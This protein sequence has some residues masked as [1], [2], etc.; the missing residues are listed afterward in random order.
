[1]EKCLDHKQFHYVEGD[2]GT[3]YFSISGK[4]NESINQ[5]F[6]HIITDEKFYNEN[7]YKWLPSD[8]YSSD[9]F[10]PKFTTYIEKMG[11]DK[12]LLGYEIEKQSQ[13]MIVLAPKMYTAFNGDSIVNLKLKG[14]DIKQTNLNNYH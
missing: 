8:F 7:I 13:H 5:G 4:V 1:M 11:F 6:K 14:V 3:L 9:N 12:K 10:N 2:T